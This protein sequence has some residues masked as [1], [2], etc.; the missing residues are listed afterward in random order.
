[1]RII[2]VIL[3]MFALTGCYTVIWLP[4]DEMP[5][6]YYQNDF[7]DNEYYGE[8]YDYY[9]TPWWIINPI[10]IYHPSKNL[11]EK[12]DRDKNS[13]N[14]RN[15]T[16]ERVIIERGGSN[17]NDYIPPITT[18][19]GNNQGSN[20]NSQN[21][22]SSSTTT[23]TNEESGRSKQNSSNDSN[24]IRNENGNRNSGNSRR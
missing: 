5:R 16:G 11:S 7:Y 19:S 15:E 1:M 9:S 24:S 22:G 23:T 3:L 10:N 6:T 17:R 21:S 8:Y 14:V 12:K 2:V 18:I 20:S 13:T 4:S